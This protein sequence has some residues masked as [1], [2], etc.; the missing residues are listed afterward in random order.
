MTKSVCFEHAQVETRK[1]FCLYVT[2]ESDARVQHTLDAV[3]YIAL[4]SRT[5][6]ITGMCRS[7]NLF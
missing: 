3:N 4:L 6:V 1:L 5:S 7:P 2:M